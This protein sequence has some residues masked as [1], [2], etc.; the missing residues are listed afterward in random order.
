MSYYEAYSKPLELL[1]KKHNYTQ[2]YVANMIGISPASVSNHE[3]GR[4]IPELMTIMHYCKLY[5]ISLAYFYQLV[6]YYQGLS[7]DTKV[8]VDIRNDVAL[9]MVIGV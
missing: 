7:T 1:R 8:D 4:T 6:A 9:G 5:D 2:T 3:N